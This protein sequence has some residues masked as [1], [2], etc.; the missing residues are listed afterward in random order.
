SMRAAAC[1]RCSQMP[2][3]IARWPIET[4]RDHA[5][6]LFGFC[7]VPA[8]LAHRDHRLGAVRHLQCF[9]DGGD[10]ILYRGLCQVEDAADRLVALALHHELE[11]IELAFSQ[12]ELRR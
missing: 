2:A 11:H 8:K 1:R 4:R 6:R 5:L 9:E 12:A 3:C 7:E 10:M